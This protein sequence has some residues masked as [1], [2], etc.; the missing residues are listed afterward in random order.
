[1]KFNQNTSR[2][3]AGALISTNNRSPRYLG[4][5]DK[6]DEEEVQTMRQHTK[7]EETIITTGR[8]YKDNGRHKKSKSTLRKHN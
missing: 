4:E 7:E 8:G 1:L 3:A 5:Y 6:T 2:G